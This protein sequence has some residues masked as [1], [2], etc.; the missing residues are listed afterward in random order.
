LTITKR[1][2]EKMGGDISLLSK[3]HERTVFSITLKRMTYWQT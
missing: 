2:I 3:P 1:L